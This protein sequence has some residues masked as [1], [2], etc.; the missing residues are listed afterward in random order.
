M[1][2]VP[3]DGRTL[4]F[5]ARA[6]SVRQFPGNTRETLPCR[7]HHGRLCIGRTLTNPP[8]PEDAPAENR[9]LLQAVQWAGSVCCA[10]AMK[11]A[12]SRIDPATGYRYCG[13]EQLPVEGRI[14]ALKDMGSTLAAI[15]G[16]LPC[17][18]DWRPHSVTC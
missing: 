17:R 8:D 10:T 12:C 6:R 18:G 14:S 1:R 16:I 3:P 7:C 2:S 15:R 9:S 4:P 5:S 13:A 11:S